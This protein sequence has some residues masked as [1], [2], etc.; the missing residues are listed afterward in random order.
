MRPTAMSSLGV[1][2][3][4]KH[5]ARIVAVAVNSGPTFATSRNYGLWRQEGR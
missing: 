4:A 1:N 2:R 5:L 3:S